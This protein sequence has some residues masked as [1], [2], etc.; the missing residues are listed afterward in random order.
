MINVAEVKGDRPVYLGH[1][2]EDH[3]QSTWAP[4]TVM[5]SLPKNGYPVT[6]CVTMAELSNCNRLSATKL[7]T[8]HLLPFTENVC[9]SLI[10]T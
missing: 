3:H 10:Y 1:C 5:N 4:V 9:K 7:K 2:P 6:F 8:F